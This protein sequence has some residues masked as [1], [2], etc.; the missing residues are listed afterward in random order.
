MRVKESTQRLVRAQYRLIASQYSYI[1]VDGTEADSLCL[2]PC[3]S[4]DYGKVLV[5]IALFRPPVGCS[6]ACQA[7]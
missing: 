6:G 3:P 1:I 7:Q 5:N 2:P 4:Q